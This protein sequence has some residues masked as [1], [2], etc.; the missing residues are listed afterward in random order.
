MREYERYR[1][2]INLRDW[3]KEEVKIWIEVV[4]MVYGIEVDFN[5]GC[6][7]VEVVEV[8]VWLVK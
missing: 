4:K 6:I 3:L 5:G 2:V 1:F 7:V 8:G